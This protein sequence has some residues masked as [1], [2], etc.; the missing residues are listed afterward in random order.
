M[1]GLAGLDFAPVAA[2]GLDTVTVP[3]GYSW[4]VVARW[5]DPLWSAGAAFDHATRGTGESQEASR[6]ATTATA[7]RSSLT[8]IAAC[9]R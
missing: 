2:N 6:S 3:D 1:P 8:A 9:S 4:Q 5:G 7:W